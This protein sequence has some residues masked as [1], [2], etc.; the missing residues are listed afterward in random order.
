[1]EN[2]TSNFKETNYETRSYKNRELK[3][4]LMSWSSQKKKEG[5]FLYRLFSPKEFF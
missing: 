3:V 1:M 4:K 5:I 2:P